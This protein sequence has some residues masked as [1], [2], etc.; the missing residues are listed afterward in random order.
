MAISSL[1]LFVLPALLEAVWYDV[2]VLYYILLKK[3][4]AVSFG[5]QKLWLENFILDHTAHLPV[6]AHL[7]SKCRSAVMRL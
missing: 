5:R 4:P 1:S 6:I 7:S 3:I 2:E